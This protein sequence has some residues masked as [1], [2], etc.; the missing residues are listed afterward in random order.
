[1]WLQAIN[2]LSVCLSANHPVLGAA[3]VAADADWECAK[4]LLNSA[5]RRVSSQVVVCVHGWTN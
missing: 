4:Q 5:C 1:M 2:A 3:A